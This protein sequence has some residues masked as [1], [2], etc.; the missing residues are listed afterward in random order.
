MKIA[1][2]YFNNI[3]GKSANVN[4]TLNMVHAF[5]NYSETTFI[6]SW[7]KKKTLNEVLLF[8]GLNQ[9]FHHKRAPVILNTSS[10]LLEKITRLVYTISVYIF[11]KIKS[12]DIIYTRDFSFLYF[13]S[14]LP[15]FMQ[16]KSV[17]Y[18][19]HKI[20][21]LTSE[22][23]TFN[24]EAKAN[25]VPEYFI[26]I[27]NGIAKDLNV[28]FAIPKEKM[29]TLPDAVNLSIFENSNNTFNKE[30]SVV[31][32]G[33]FLPWKGVNILIEAIALIKEKY[34]LRVAIAGGG[35]NEEI[36]SIN[37]LIKQNNLE[38]TIEFKGF[39]SQQEVAN[40]ISR[41]NI[42]VI[43]NTSELISAKY[44]SP[45]KA[46]EYMAGRTA[47]VASNLD[48]MKEIFEENKDC[49][50]FEPGNAA[51]LASKLELLLN[52]KNL[53]LSLQK[54]AYEKATKNSWE[55]RAKNIVNIAKIIR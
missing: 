5:S 15:S 27:S 33:S 36:N 42:S 52:N 34:Q 54:K 22:K 46:F 29:T 43:P 21:H 55:A 13:L 19:P 23:V 6:S 51:S 24:Q 44:T 48:S 35:T 3:S 26:P 40:L 31:Y 45:L 41:S 53:M 1:Y 18:E 17:V 20:Y 47:I 50:F 25:M 37:N 7:I 49:L 32:T 39:L 16:L 8:F 4:Q 14:L 30:L 9:N 10:S 12:F 38:N 11:L 2:V 28:L